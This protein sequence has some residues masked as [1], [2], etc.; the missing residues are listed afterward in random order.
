MNQ[1]PSNTNNSATYSGEVVYIYAFDLAYDMRKVPI[2][3]LLGQPTSEY[4]VGP[5]KRSPKQMMFYRPQM[6]KLP[7]ETWRIQD[8]D[9]QINRTVKIFSVGAISILISVPFENLT[10]KDLIDYHEP[11]AKGIDWTGYINGL[12]ENIRSELEPYCLRPNPRV[13]IAEAYTVF[14]FYGLPES[15]RTEQWLSENQA[16]IAALLTQEENAESLSA[17]QVRESTAQSVSYYQNDLVI[18]DW[19]AAVIVAG[20]EGL[21]NILHIVELANVQ[22]VE[23]AAYDRLLDSSLERAY[24]DL[25]Q[26]R[27]FINRTIHK[28]LREISVDLTR[29]SDELINITKFFGDWYL[30]KIYKTLSARFHLDDWDKVINEKLLALGEL[31]RMLQQD[32]VN[33][34]M[35][36]LEATIVLL[37]V[38]DLLLLIAKAI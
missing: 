12:A 28:Y 34:W 16:H 21:D 19:D 27:L 13:G 9:I 5:D 35:M 11:D 30:A 6:V 3:E 18:A 32:T 20:H 24:R 31:Y 38:I 4:S 2:S 10:L 14:C 1:D 26:R 36:L 25:A 17:Q 7:P 23:L 8:R 29:L 15:R 33:F 37:F 22:L